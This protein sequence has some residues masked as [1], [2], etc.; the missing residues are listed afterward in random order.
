MESLYE[1]GMSIVLLFQG[2]GGWLL[3]PMKLF[4]FLGSVEFSLLVMP[5]LY[6]SIDATLG[7]RIGLILLFSNVINYY[8]KVGIHAG[9]PFWIS[10]Q[11]EAHA[12]ESSFAL[13]SAHAQNSAAVLG[14]LAATLKRWWVWGISLLLIFLIGVSR[15]YLAVHFP[16][17]VILGWLI[18][19]LL[20]WLFLRFEK[21]VAAWF[22]T[23]TLPVSILVLFVISISMLLLG[24]L[25]RSL[26]GS[27]QIP[28]AWIENARFAFPEEE[29]HQPAECIRITAQQWSLL[30]SIL[31][32][33][34]ALNPGG[35]LG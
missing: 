14:L 3:A 25:L 33:P 10:R 11:V 23:Q 15:I 30:W 22:S 19:F 12:F 35:I 13:P 21:P 6:W 5:F 32:C 29:D 4:S 17:D 2:L 9:R 27:W 31:W 20:V 28:A 34:L 7:I 16:Q 26:V 1:L 18:G 24:L 8:L